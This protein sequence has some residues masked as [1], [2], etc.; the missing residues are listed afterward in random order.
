MQEYN[1]GIQ[2]IPAALFAGM[3]GFT[4]KDFFDL[5]AA[6][7]VVETGPAGEVLAAPSFRRRAPG[8]DADRFRAIAAGAAYGLYTISIQQAS[9]FAAAAR[10]CSFLVYRHGLSPAR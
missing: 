4:R 9:S 7:A 5:G 2:Q 1:T 3:F 6:R 10:V 8:L